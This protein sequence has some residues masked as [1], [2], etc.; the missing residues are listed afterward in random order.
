[1]PFFG[2]S[3][4]FDLFAEIATKIV[5]HS[6]TVTPYKYLHDMTKTKPKIFEKI[7]VLAMMK[8]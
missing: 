3:V 8:K 2:A 6:S 1:V 5:S 4:S 7:L